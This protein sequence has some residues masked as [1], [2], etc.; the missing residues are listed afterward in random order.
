MVV[1]VLPTLVV[2]LQL[3]LL[4]ETSKDTKFMPQL[5]D[6]GRSSK[7]TIEGS[8]PSWGAKYAYVLQLEDRLVLEI[9]CCGF[10]AHRRYQNIQ[11][12]LVW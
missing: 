2:H 3:I 10:E 1:E 11:S 12:E 8:N 5:A 6:S 7:S 9:R 4:K